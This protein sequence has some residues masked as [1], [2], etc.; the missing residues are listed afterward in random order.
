MNS[1]KRLLAQ[2]T[3][4][5]LAIVRY[6]LQVRATSFLQCKPIVYR[7]HWLCYLE[8]GQAK[9]RNTGRKW[10]L[11]TFLTANSLNLD[12]NYLS[13]VYLSGLYDNLQISIDRNP[14]IF[15]S[16]IF[17]NRSQVAKLNYVHVKGI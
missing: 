10:S 3:I 2:K 11:A 5:D 12:T 8:E 1:S 9:I 17:A 16:M 15:E 4:I 7:C 13:A 14:L 6:L